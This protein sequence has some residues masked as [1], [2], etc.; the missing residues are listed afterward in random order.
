MANQKYKRDWLEPV[1]LVLIQIFNLLGLKA[2]Q[3]CLVWLKSQTK[4]SKLFSALNSKLEFKKPDD[5]LTIT[6]TARIF[7]SWAF[8]YVGASKTLNREGDKISSAYLYFT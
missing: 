5:V 7:Q 3:A 8:P 6:T 2:A 4:H 1:L